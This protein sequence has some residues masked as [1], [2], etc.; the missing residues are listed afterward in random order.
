MTIAMIALRYKIAIK[1]EEQFSEETFEQRK[2]RVLK[3]KPGVSM[4]CVLLFDHFVG[5]ERSERW[6]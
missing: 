4:T 1:Q 5:R 3:S 2:A 6:L